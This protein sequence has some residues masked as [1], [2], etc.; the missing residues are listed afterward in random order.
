MNI[1]V[2]K[3]YEVFSILEYIIT[4]KVAIKHSV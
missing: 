4:N 2:L 3:L 1:V